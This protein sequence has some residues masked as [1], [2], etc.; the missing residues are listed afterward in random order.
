MEIFIWP[1]LLAVLL[2]LPLL[3]LVHRRLLKP[4]ARAVLHHPDVDLLAQAA[5]SGRRWTRRLPALAYFAA[6]ALAL[7]AMARPTMAVPEADPHAGIILALDVSRSMLAD[8]VAPTRIEAARDAMAVFVENLPAGTRIGLV[9]FAG[10]ASL[11]VPLT[12]D[13]Q[14][15]LQAVEVIY[16]GRGT[17]I[18]SAL[19]ESLRA[20]PSLEERLALGGDPRSYATIVLLSD[21]ANRGG[22]SPSVA[23]QD[24]I[25]QQV[26]VHTI[27]VGNASSAYNQQYDPFGGFG[28]SMQFDESTLRMIAEQSGGRFA[29]VESA[30]ELNDVYRDLSRAL[31]WRIRR[32]E[33]TGVAAL[34]AALLLFASVTTAQLRRLV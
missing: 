11:V 20:L 19:I 24:V 10:Y 25:V 8:D 3:L 33:A 1:Y 28:F 18:G 22:V 23:I 31:A 30:D 7:V 15:V 9:T 32:D 16:L 17:V 5:A 34:A 13:H 29:M 14:R 4:P 21:G 26:T 2:A 27:G 12:D 6:V